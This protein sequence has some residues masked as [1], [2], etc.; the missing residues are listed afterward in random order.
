MKKDKSYIEKEKAFK[1]QIEI[2]KLKNL[3]LTAEQDKWCKLISKQICKQYKDYAV[4]CEECS[5]KPEGY[6]IDNGAINIYHCVF[7]EN[8]KNKASNAAVEYLAMLSF[9]DPKF[10]KALP[11]YIFNADKMTVGNKTFREAFL[12]EYETIFQKKSIKMAGAGKGFKKFCKDAKKSLELINKRYKETELVEN[13]ELKEFLDHKDEAADMIQQIK[14]EKQN[15][16]ESNAKK[17]D[18]KGM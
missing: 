1:K 5:V 11:N 2:E 14:A 18:G 8:T 12:S 13:Y 16:A 17:D 4:F 15:G 6:G 3:A 10:I 7:D 9:N